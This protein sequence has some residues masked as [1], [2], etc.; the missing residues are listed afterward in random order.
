MRRSV[1]F[2]GRITRQKG[3]GHLIA[4]AHAFDPGVQLVLCAG[5]PD[6]PEIAAETAAAVAALQRD[7]PGVF[8][9]DGMLTRDEVL[10]V[11]SAATVFCCPSVYEPLGIVN[12]EAMACEAAVVASDVGGIPEV[13]D[14]GVTGTPGALRRRGRRGIRGRH[15]SCGQRTRSPIRPGLDGW[16][17]P[18]GSGRYRSSPGP[19]WPERPSTCTGACSA[20]RRR[21]DRWSTVRL[22]PDSTAQKCRGTRGLRTA[23]ARVG[24]RRPDP[25]GRRSLL[26]DGGLS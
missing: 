15:R 18:A 7:R 1:A 12:L 3:V 8:W 17:A 16:A 10:Q 25:G 23:S 21:L 2:V 26:S 11:L 6:T 20:E 24:P 22:G 19:R 14:D 4:A 13:V 9:L 5:A